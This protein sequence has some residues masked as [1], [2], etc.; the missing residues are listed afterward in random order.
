LGCRSRAS[1]EAYRDV[2]R[3]R[4]PARRPKLAESRTSPQK[5]NQGGDS[6]KDKKGDQHQKDSSKDQ[7]KGNESENKQPEPSEKGKNDLS[8]EEAEQ[9]L[10]MLKEQE[11]DKIKQNKAMQLGKPKNKDDKK[12]QTGEDW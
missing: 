7:D 12:A 2:R 1:P 4:W 8:K 9:I 10:Q 11:S 6:Q 3:G 5:N